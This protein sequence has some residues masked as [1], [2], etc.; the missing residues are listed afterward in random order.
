MEV[1]VIGFILY[2]LV[3]Y[4]FLFYEDLYFVKF[5]LLIIVSKILNEERC[6]RVEIGLD[7]CFFSI[8]NM[9]DE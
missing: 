1:E 3:F 2:I 4:S 9:F 5:L 7:Y 6:L 8:L